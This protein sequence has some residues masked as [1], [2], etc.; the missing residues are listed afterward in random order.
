VSC[1]K[2]I[3]NDKQAVVVLYDRS[4]VLYPL[5]LNTGLPPLHSIV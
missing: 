2:Y 3:I 1:I 4:N 5:N